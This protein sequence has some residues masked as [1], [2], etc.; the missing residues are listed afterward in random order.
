MTTTKQVSILIYM[1]N[2]DRNIRTL[3][4]CFVIALVALIPL[5]IVESQNLMNENTMVLGEETEMVEEVV[6]EEVELPNAE[7]LE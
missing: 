1:T 6:E 2:Q 5:R 3:I 7:I 4:T